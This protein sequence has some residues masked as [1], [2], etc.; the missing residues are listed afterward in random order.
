M[1][2]DIDDKLILVKLTFGNQERIFKMKESDA[3]KFIAEHR[4]IEK[5]YSK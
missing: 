2:I 3:N 4:R 5:M 1:S